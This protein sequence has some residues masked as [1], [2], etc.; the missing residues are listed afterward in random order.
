MRSGIILTAFV[1]LL[2]ATA[3]RAQDPATDPAATDPAATDSAVVAPA[4][5]PAATAPP[6][7][8][9]GWLGDR[10]TLGV[11]DLI[12]V[13]VDE[14]T[15]SRE[16]VSTI[17]IG[18]RTQRA[19]LNARGVSPLNI[20]GPTKEFA[21]ELTNQS[22]NSGEAGRTAGLSAVLTVRVTGFEANG[23]ARIE[24]QKS[25]STDGRLQEVTLKGIVRPQDVTADN[26]V[27]S[28]RIANAVITYKGKKIAPKSGLLGGILNV[29]WP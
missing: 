18:D 14:Q 27:L 5:A 26:K 15:V 4:A 17:A 11:G 21:T 19:G 10:R 7:A 28:S 16:H 9:A 13:L 3:A 12:T 1:T 8:R 23:A 24:G 22:R 29:L 25:V 2:A 6:V 20:V